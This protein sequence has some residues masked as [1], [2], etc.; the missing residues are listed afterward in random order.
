MSDYQN[1]EVPSTGSPPVPQLVIEHAVTTDFIGTDE[2][3]PPVEDGR[4]A[5]VR[6]LPHARTLWRRV[7]ISEIPL[8]R[9]R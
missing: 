4:W 5:L 1:S 6:R 9:G 3:W 2:P 8:L 7:A